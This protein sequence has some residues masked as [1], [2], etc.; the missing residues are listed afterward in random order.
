MPFPSIN[1][2][3]LVRLSCRGHRRA[4]GKKTE[5][6]MGRGLDRG[7]AWPTGIFIT[8]VHRSP[9]ET[10]KSAWMLVKAL[11]YVPKT[12]LFI[13]LAAVVRTQYASRAGAEVMARQSPPH[14][15]LVNEHTSEQP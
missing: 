12:C 13:Y 2:G 9:E 15:L 7:G 8:T 6:R 14:N 10:F 3:G 11:V 5:G 1:A 4:C